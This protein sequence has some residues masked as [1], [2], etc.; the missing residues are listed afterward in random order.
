M[1]SIW[2]HEMASLCP[3]K[4]FLQ[5]SF[6]MPRVVYSSILFN[7]KN[8]KSVSPVISEKTSCSTL[9]GLPYIFFSLNE[10]NCQKLMFKK[11]SAAWKSE[12]SIDI[13][14]IPEKYLH[15]RY[16]RRWYRY[17]S[18]RNGIQKVYIFPLV[19]YN[20]LVSVY[21]CVQY[22]YGYGADKRK[23]ILWGTRAWSCRND[24]DMDRIRNKE[25]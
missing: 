10:I 25:V 7:I 23:W 9:F 3:S 13:L 8:F 2:K 4:T 19:L 21:E 22:E 16:S 5:K 1:C 15:E 12:I 14:S 24:T 11:T 6:Y 17:G 18:G 20:M